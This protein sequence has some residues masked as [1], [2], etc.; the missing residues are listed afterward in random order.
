MHRNDH[1]RFAEQLSAPAK[2]SVRSEPILWKNNV[3][4]T[5]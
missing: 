3:L 2:A 4:R 1:R 5:T